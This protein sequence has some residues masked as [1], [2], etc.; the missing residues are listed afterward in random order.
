[1]NPSVLWT[2]LCLPKTGIWGPNSRCGAFGG[3]AFVNWWDLDKVIRGQRRRW[4][5]GITS[6][7]D[8]SLTNSGRQW[9]TGKPG[10]LQSL[11]LQRIGHDLAT[12]QQQ[13]CERWGPWWDWH[14]Y[15]LYGELALSSSTGAHS[16]KAGVCKPGRGP[17]PRIQARPQ[18]PELWERKL[19]LLG[20]RCLWDSVTTALQDEDSWT[21]SW[22]AAPRNLWTSSSLGA[23]WRGFQLW[24]MWTSQEE[25]I[26]EDPE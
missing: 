5:E 20:P 14:P 22:V 25:G 18:P 21:L 6:S 9:R 17:S 7:M 15:V 2:T 1:M 13:W 11:G 23:S 24:T 26:K 19:L 10:M 12:D 4:L 8:R 3:R 16:Q